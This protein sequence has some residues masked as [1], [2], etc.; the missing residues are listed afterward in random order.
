[1]PLCFTD[2]SV[3]MVKESVGRGSVIVLHSLKASC[4][5]LKC[6]SSSLDHVILSCDFRPAMACSSGE[7]KQAYP[8]ST[9]LRTLYAPE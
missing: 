7:V 3:T 2:A 4:A 1:M 8:C 6:S 9:L 5:C